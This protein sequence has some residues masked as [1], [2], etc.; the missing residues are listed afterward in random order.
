M[1]DFPPLKLL[2]KS[3]GKKFNKGPKLKCLLWENKIEE[4]HKECFTLW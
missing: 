1:M 2:P 3:E 4:S